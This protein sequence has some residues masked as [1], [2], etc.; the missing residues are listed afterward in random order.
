VNQAKEV[1][2]MTTIRPQQHAD[3]G[4]DHRGLSIALPSSATGGVL[5]V[6]DCDIPAA[7]AGPPLHIH[8][9][10]DETFIVQ[11]GT[12]LVYRDGDVAELGAGDLVHIPRGTRHTFATPPAAAARFLTLHTPGGFERFHAAAADV[13]RRRGAPLPQTELIDLAGGF[14]WQLAGP[15]LLPTGVLPTT[16]A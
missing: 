1:S 5:A 10:S 15:P 14:D 13:E 8:P 4:R 2:S 12:L 6:V 9:A 3:V 16:T 11:S 7:T